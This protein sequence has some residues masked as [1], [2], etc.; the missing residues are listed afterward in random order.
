MKC[1]LRFHP[2]DYDYGGATFAVRKILTDWAAIDWFV[3]APGEARRIRAIHAFEAHHA[4]AH[5]AMPE[6]FGTSV[7]VRTCIGGWDELYALYERVALSPWSSWVSAAASTGSPQEGS[8]RWDWKFGALKKMTRAHSESRAFRIKD[9]ARQVV[10][11]EDLALRPG[12]LFVCWNGMV[13]WHSVYSEFDFREWLP[14][15]EATVASWYLSYANMDVTECIEWQL[16]ENTD[17]LTKN[18]FAP[19]LSCYAAGFYPFS[20]APNEVVLFG[21]GCSS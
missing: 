14:P 6:V 20:L 11:P 18:P 1:G 13:L 5:A 10:D 21:F 4:A 16:A 9:V 17:D 19:L 7:A 15:R 8:P 12:E 2:A 3:P